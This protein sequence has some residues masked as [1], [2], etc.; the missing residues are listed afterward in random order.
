M[1]KNNK[2]INKY[3]SESKSFRTNTIQILWYF[4]KNFLVH[5]HTRTL[6]DVMMSL[7]KI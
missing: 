5:H 2:K 7:F 6:L 4:S 3:E 1:E